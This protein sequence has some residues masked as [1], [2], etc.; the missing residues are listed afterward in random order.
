KLLGAGEV[1]A[2]GR[3]PD[4]LE[5]A[6][7][8]GADQ[9]VRLTG[10]AKADAAAVAAAASEV[11]IVLDYLWGSVTSAVMPAICRRRAD[12][13]RALR[14]VLIG[15]MAGDELAL[16]SVLLRKRNLVILGSGQGA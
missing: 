5:R 2:V 12:E 10:D 11:D 15:S 9:I 6:R 3:S 7:G 8:L 4:A 16:S 14:W 13:A 1:I